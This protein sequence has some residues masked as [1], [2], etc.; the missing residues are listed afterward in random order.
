[1]YTARF[2]VL[3]AC[4]C[5]VKFRLFADN[6]ERLQLKSW[7]WWLYSFFLICFPAI[8]LRVFEKMLCVLIVLA[9]K[10]MDMRNVIPASAEVAI[11]YDTDSSSDDD[12][13]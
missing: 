11:Q 7:L 13:D 2:G 10:Q 9:Q 12:D 5:E 8:Q 1:M 4:F 3:I 6:I